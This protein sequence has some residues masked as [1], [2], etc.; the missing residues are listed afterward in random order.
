ML[1]QKNVSIQNESVDYMM[2]EIKQLKTQIALQK[3]EREVGL[4]EAAL[5]ASYAE[6]VSAMTT[7]WSWRVSAMHGA[8]AKP[9]NYMAFCC[10]RNFLMNILCAFRNEGSYILILEYKF[11]RQFFGE[12]FRFSSLIFLAVQNVPPLRVVSRAACGVRVDQVSAV[13][14]I[15]V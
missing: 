7:F 6:E 10:H 9:L 12:L 14:F 3:S 11:Y 5:R 2:E 8:L 15:F 13:V 1:F 4:T